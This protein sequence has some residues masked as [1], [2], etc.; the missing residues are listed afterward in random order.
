MTQFYSSVC[1][2]IYL[3]VTP[4][5]LYTGYLQPPVSMS[6]VLSKYSFAENNPFASNVTNSRGIPIGQIE[7]DV[8][9]IEVS[10]E[11][12][13]T[14]FLEPTTI[15]LYNSSKNQKSAEYTFADL[16][17]WRDDKTFHPLNAKRELDVPSDLV[18]YVCFTVELNE[19]NTTL[20][21][22][23]RVD[24]YES[25]NLMTH[26]EYSVLITTGVLFSVGAVVVVLFHVA[27]PFNIAI[28]LVGVQS[29]LL[30]LVRGIY[31]FLL[32]QDVIPA[33]SLLDF[34]LIEIPTFF[35]IGI[36][37]EIII[38]VYCIVFPTESLTTLRT[39]VYVAL[40]LLLNWIA[41]AAIMIAISV[42]QN[43]LTE[44]KSCNCR[45]SQPTEQ[46]DRAEIVR[47]VYKS[48][49]LAFAVVVACVTI[50]MGYRKPSIRKNRL[51]FFQM[52]S[53]SLGLVMDCVAF[54]IYYQLN[55]P[56]ADFVIVL[57]FTELLPIGT[58]NVLIGWS[59][60]R[61]FIAKFLN[62]IRGN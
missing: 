32:A 26:A 20:V 35:Y 59:E 25:V 46:T 17:V 47:L 31:F 51:V 4:G 1:V 23:E 55:R 3:F 56:N 21:L 10:P 42:G 8:L 44:T 22:I 19:T 62:W 37:L 15:C 38:V 54:L 40:A 34:A 61:Y 16:G 60:S 39:S 12:N 36:F 28:I 7:S 30:F 50:F 49:V 2:R 11:R 24:D 45:I 14:N 5:R 41:F 57:W 43:S 13:A 48:I 29:V 27:L 6:F 52:I 9:Q 53:L 58:L 33:G 18:G